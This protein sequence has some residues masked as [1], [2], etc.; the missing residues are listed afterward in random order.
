M[1][2]GAVFPAAVGFTQHFPIVNMKTNPLH[3][4][5]T[6]IFG[7]GISAGMFVSKE[8]QDYKSHYNSHTDLVPVVISNDTN[9]TEEAEI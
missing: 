8:F 7:R 2:L 6:T 5:K 1:I 9:E 4:S 3:R